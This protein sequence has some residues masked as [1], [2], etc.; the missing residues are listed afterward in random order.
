MTRGAKS[1]KVR[2]PISSAVLGY[3]DHFGGFVF[4]PILHVQQFTMTEFGV[5]FIFDFV[6]L[7]YDI[8]PK[9]L[10][11]KKIKSNLEK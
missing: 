2:G 4:A 10:H 9:S 3:F 8:G 11:T 1:A 7:Y 6:I 5:F